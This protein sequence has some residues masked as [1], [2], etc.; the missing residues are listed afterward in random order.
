MGHE[1]ALT[2]LCTG[3]L[4]AMKMMKSLGCTVTAAENP[5]ICMYFDTCS[6]RVFG[7]PVMNTSCVGFGEFY[8]AFFVDLIFKARL[9]LHESRLR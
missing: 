8:V 1:Q 7:F 3:Y 2:F 5:C 4:V 6:K 9:F